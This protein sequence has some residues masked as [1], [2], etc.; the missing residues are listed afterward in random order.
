MKG[1]AGPRSE[2]FRKECDFLCVNLIVILITFIFFLMVVLVILKVPN[3]TVAP[4]S[5]IY[6]WYLVDV[7]MT[8]EVMMTLKLATVRASEVTGEGTCLPGSHAKRK[9]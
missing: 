6:A 5:Q 1:Y 4:S 8:G 3:N 2:D 9:R 7:F